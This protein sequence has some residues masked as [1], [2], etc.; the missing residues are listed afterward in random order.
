MKVTLLVVLVLIFNISLAAFP[1][2][3]L[4]GTATAS[5]QV[6][7][8]WN[9][10]RGLTIWDIFSHTPGKTANGDT[11]DVADDNYHRF[12]ED[13]ALMKSLG[14]KASR[15]SI[16]WSRLFPT[17]RPPANPVG[18]QFYNDL[19]NAILANG[20]EPFVT[21]YH[22]DLPNDLPNGWLS[23][24]IVDDFAVYAD[25]VFNAYGDR[26]KKWITFNEPL[27]FTWLGYGTGQHAPGR[28]S[29]RTICTAGN[30]S[31]EP[32]IAAHNV[33]LAHAEAVQIYRKKYQPQQKG[34][35]GIT[36]NCDWA[37]PYSESDADVLAAQRHLEFQLAWYADPV[38]KGDYPES[39]KFLVGDRLPTFTPFQKLIVNGSWDYFGLNHYT[40]GYSQNNPNPPA[41]GGWSA[42]Q[43]VNVLDTRNGQLIGPRADSS[44][45]Y[46][47]PF[48]INRM[49][50]WVNERY[51]SP[52]IY[53][54]ENGVDVPN[55]N[56][57][58][59]PN[60]LHDQFRIQFY[61]QYISNVS[62]AIT[63]GVDVRG[64]FAWSF[65]DNFEWADGYTKRFGL[66]YVDYK[67]NLT[68]FSKDSAHWFSSLINQTTV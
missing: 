13:I 23:P 50:K 53:I 37:V 3:F 43:R 9:V 57:I 66:N 11:G 38:F 26:V 39:M 10:S 22:W 35:I 67:N 8:A 49:L 32:Y 62:L 27:S 55:E 14:F 52:P 4:W 36:L 2:D 59:L 29:N 42:D 19:I 28:C 48:G 30:S 63:Q 41:D 47:V 24:S 54:T 21:L 58:P 45:L 33:L 18:F 46:V 68:R 5:Y 25:A 60:V 56:S 7:G 1:K 61:E 40:T 12:L 6:E 64:Y 65:M 17:G 20:M 51:N 44:W 15:F 34:V 31:T 16:A